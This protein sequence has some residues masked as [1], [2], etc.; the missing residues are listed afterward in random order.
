MVSYGP[1]LWSYAYGWWGSYVRWAVFQSRVV[2]GFLVIVAPLGVSMTAYVSDAVAGVSEGV[3][4][5]Y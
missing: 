1:V 5:E 2:C 4:I 3:R